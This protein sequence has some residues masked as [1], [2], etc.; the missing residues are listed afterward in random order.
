MGQNLTIHNVKKA[1]I[2]NECN[3]NVEKSLRP[4]KEHW[5]W[6]LWKRSELRKLWNITWRHSTGE[7]KKIE[8][9]CS[10]GKCKERDSRPDAKTRFDRTSVWEHDI[11]LGEDT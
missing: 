11:G 8:V 9:P 6:H 5:E 3:L 4:I 7:E 1:H 2:K 10:S